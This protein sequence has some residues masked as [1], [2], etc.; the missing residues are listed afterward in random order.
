MVYLRKKK[1]RGNNYY[2]IVEGKL[3]N[4][5]VKQK[6]LCYVGTA[7]TLLKKLR[8]LKKTLKKNKD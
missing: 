6:V 5:K 1:I 3:V 4:G 7:E 8:E 2:Y